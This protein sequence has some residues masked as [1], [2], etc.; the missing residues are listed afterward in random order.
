[1]SIDGGGIKGLAAIKILQEITNKTGKQPFELFDIICGTST[2]GIIAILLGLLKVPLSSSSSDTKSDACG[3][4]SSHNDRSKTEAIDCESLY[5]NLC[6][7]IF[8]RP[9]SSHWI[10]APIRW[11]LGWSYY[12]TKVLEKEILNVVGKDKKMSD[13]PNSLEKGVPRVF[14][15]S[16]PDKAHKNYFL[17]NN[18]EEN[19]NNGKIADVEI[20]KAARATSAAPTYFDKIKIGDFEFMDGGFGTNNPSMVAWSECKEIFREKDVLFVSIGLGHPTDANSSSWFEYLKLFKTGLEIITGC[21]ATHIEMAAIAKQKERLEYHRLNPKG[22]GRI[23]LDD[24]LQVDEIKRIV[25]QYLM[26]VDVEKVIFALK[27]NS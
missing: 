11:T 16:K 14:V 23:E 17:F 7:E 1:M 25:K 18:Y 20:W 24:Y 27:E 26:D 9:W 10:F 8:S 21:E 6:K 2:G 4:A 3:D 5:T 19:D 12:N 13:I 22:L 15:T